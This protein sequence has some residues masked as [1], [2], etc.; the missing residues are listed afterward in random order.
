MTVTPIGMAVA[1]ILQL[2]GNSQLESGTV[3][4]SMG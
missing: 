3:F 1:T 4:S 2:G